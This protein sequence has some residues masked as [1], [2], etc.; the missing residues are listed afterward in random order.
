M[1]SLFTADEVKL[2]KTVTADEVKLQKTGEKREL[3]ELRS[4]LARFAAARD[5][6]AQRVAALE[7]IVQGLKEDLAEGSQWQ[8]RKDEESEIEEVR[9]CVVRPT[10]PKAGV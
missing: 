3:E 10:P 1:G 7:T 5:E 2:Q 4:Q 9:V 8:R 6:D